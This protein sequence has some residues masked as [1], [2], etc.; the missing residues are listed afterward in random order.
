MKRHATTK[1][2]TLAMQGVPSNT[3]LQKYAGVV[4]SL[5][6]LIE[7]GS[8]AKH[9]QTAGWQRHA[10]AHAAVHHDLRAGLHSEWCPLPS[11]AVGWGSSRAGAHRIR[12]GAPRRR[13]P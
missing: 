6:T 1:T 7:T 11:A 10:R 9:D 4:P 13:Q 3:T 12:V 5:A 2:E 8:H